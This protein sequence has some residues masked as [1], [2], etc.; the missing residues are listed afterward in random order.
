M[1]P[2]LLALALLPGL[3]AAEPRQHGDLVIDLSDEW[4][5]GN[6]DEAG[7]VSYF[8]DGPE[9]RCDLCR[10]MIA[11]SQPAQGDLT[12]WLGTQAPIFVDEDDTAEVTSPAEPIGDMGRPF[13]MMG[14]TVGRDIQI[15][16]GLEA[17]GRR[18]A[19][20]FEGWAYDQEEIE[21]TIG[22]LQSDIVPLMEGLTFVSEGAP[23][24]MPEAQPGN[25]DGLLW[26]WG[27]TLMPGINGSL[28]TDISV[29]HI[30][31][32][33]DGTFYDG[34][35]V[36]GLGPLDKK[37]REGSADWGTYR[38]IDGAIELSFV[39]GEVE[40]LVAE[41]DGWSD[42]T[43]TFAR[44]EP[45]PDGAP[46]DGTLESLF[47]SGMGFGESA[48]TVAS[49]STTV[50]HAD[51]TYEGESFGSGSSESFTALS[52]NVLGG[53]Y[54]VR[55]GLLVLTPADGSEPRVS[56]VYET[57]DDGIMIDDGFLE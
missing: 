40:Q 17:D 50:F 26:G 19:V 20:A 11:P 49:G 45:L 54:E 13:A 12:Q 4:S 3:A 27:T 31:F 37:A 41:G 34:T 28:M 33:P 9:E 16:M 30:A 21:R 15:V 46:V 39:D 18:T 32:W 57:T 7:V 24:L 23:P 56:W 1:R 22:F 47:V 42:G 35:P 38:E 29:R 48:T 52:E 53:T 10:L 43:H 25:L 5:G 14:Q 55:D 44:A 2:L 6:A 36:T 51:G 8:Y